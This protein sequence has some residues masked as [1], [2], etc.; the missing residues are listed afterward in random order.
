MKEVT[1]LSEAIALGATSVDV[2]VCHREDES[3]VGHSGQY[4]MK[5]LLAGLMGSF[6]SEIGR[7]D[8]WAAR[9]HNRLVRAGADSGKRFVDVRV[10]RPSNPLWDSLSFSPLTLRRG[11]N[12]GAMDAS[13]EESWEDLI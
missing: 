13:L 10:L 7:R 3:V 2:I 9:L 1:P 5:H 12:L 4:S 6:L 8:F 11:F